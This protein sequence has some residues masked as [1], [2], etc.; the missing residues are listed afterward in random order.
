MLGETEVQSTV[1]PSPAPEPV[2]P[3]APP[4][5]SYTPPAYVPPT[6][7]F[8]LGPLL[9][10]FFLVILVAGA[11][12]VAYY[13][14]KFRTAVT[15]SPTPTIEPSVLPSPSLASSATP[16]AT[17]KT[18]LN[19]SAK[20]T[21]KPTPT[22]TPFSLPGLDLRFGN[23]S[24]NVKQTIDENNGAGR[25]INREY[26]SIQAGQFDEVSSTL[27]PKVTVCYHLVA[28][29][30]MAGKLIKFS[31]TVDDKD[32]VSDTM[33]WIDNLEAGRIY[34]WCHDVTTSIGKHTAKLT[35]NGDK[36]V[37][38]ANYGNDIASVTWENLADN[39]APNFTVSGP[40]DWGDN[41]TC[42]L[43]PSAP[44]DNVT[45]SKDLKI[46]QKVDGGNWTPVV[47]AQY[48]FKGTSGSTHTYAV[49]VVDAR[50]N[51]AEQ[52]KTFQLF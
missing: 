44:T 11:V 10:G 31:M 16:S 32:E 22:A 36:S 5:P 17:P 37:K 7:K 49:H 43:I 15:P 28:S 23:P 29:E 14:A 6:S 2:A 35:I 25:V 40:F 3:P 8:S 27:S 30:A 34:D 46:E 13:T 19:Q 51:S 9:L 42:L 52:V 20:P 18:S 24:A 45:A 41:G 1:P 38:E 50:N 4:T 21:S 39:V 48:C 47:G 12:G 33:S 26:T